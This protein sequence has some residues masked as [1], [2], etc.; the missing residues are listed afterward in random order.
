MQNTVYGDCL[1]NFLS[2]FMQLLLLK[3][4]I[5]RLKYTLPFLKNAVDQTWNHFHFKSGPQWKDQKS[6]CQ[7]KQILP[8]FRK[9]FT[10]SHG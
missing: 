4:A 5:A 9:L 10:Q 6:S 1:Q 8:L 3:R 2:H 7:V